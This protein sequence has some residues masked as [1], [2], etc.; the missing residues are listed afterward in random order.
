[1]PT[2]DQK[3]FFSFLAERSA[4][5]IGADNLRKNLRVRRNMRIKLGIDPTTPDLHLGHVVP[6]R[7]LR[8]FQDAGHR[9]VLIIGDFTSQIGDPSGKAAGRRQMSLA[10]TRS[11]ERT[12]RMQLGKVLDMKKAEIRHNGEWYQ[13]MRLK[14]FLD[15]LTRF[16]LKG[17][18]EREDFQKRIRAGKEVGVHEAM[19]QVLQ[20]YDSVMVRSDV[21]IG[22]LDQK[23]NILAGRELQ[24]KLGKI[25]QS[26]VLIPYMIGLDGKQ[27]MSKSAGN[28]INLND[29]AADMFG[30]IMSI[31]DEIIVNYAELGA[32]LPG[33]E[34]Q[35]IK[36]RFDD[37]ENPRDIKLEVARS[38]IELYHGRA[39][40][41][42]A[43]DLFLQLFSKKDISA[44]LPAVRLKPGAY[45]PV[46]LLMVIRAASSRSEARRL[47]KG[48]AMEVDGLVVDN[49][50]LEI[51]IKPGSVIKVGKKK[52][53]R[54]S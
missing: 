31:P 29:S 47:V 15:L 10:E 5:I 19:Y 37:G 33:T 50:Q 34:V 40:A 46:G 23:L 21:E 48:R 6:L 14:D 52:F 11:N 27:K 36:K 30:K 24:K 25:P 41:K 43:G 1:M 54:V 39:A 2:L 9:A 26:I 49:I 38:I 32:W 51:P 28:T 3:T 4:E 17:V 13:N 45:D 8:A 44:S 42:R 7:M 12:Y 20:A 22:S 35:A 53:F 18:W 16:S